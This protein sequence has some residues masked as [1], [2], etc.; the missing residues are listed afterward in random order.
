MVQKLSPQAG[1]RWCC[2][3]EEKKQKYNGE[4]LDGKRTCI[5]TE[6][7]LISVESILHIISI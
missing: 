1:G 5:I 3:K 6:A 7:A 4:L 2:T